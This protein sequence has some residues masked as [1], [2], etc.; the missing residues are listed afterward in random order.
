MWETYSGECLYP[1]SPIL[2]LF[3]SL[4]SIYVLLVNASR[5]RARQVFP[6][7]HPAPASSK[8]G[9]WVFFHPIIPWQVPPLPALYLIRGRSS[10][11]YCQR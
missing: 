5:P 4:A 8:G 6:P 3:L 11:Q 1:A 10:P 9:R 2:A 7:R